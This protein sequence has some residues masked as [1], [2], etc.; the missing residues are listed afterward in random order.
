MNNRT[1]MILAAGVI[2]AAASALSNPALAQRYSSDGY[3]PDTAATA[4]DA[5]KKPETQH[6]AQENEWLTEERE[7]GSSLPVT[8]IP[9]PARA[10]KATATAR[11]ET[12]RQEAENDWLTA[13][14]ERGNSLPV[15]EIPFPVPPA[16][17]AVANPKPGY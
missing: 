7:R 13:E 15:T 17:D 12:A 11:P 3:Y 16:T 14:R 8:D 6:Q 9:F 2:A 4:T 1:K 5:G 10:A